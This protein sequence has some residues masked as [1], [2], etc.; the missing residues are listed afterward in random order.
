[1]LNILKKTEEIYF[2]EKMRNY[3]ISKGEAIDLQEWT[4]NY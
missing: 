4:L 1:M 2:K 3:K